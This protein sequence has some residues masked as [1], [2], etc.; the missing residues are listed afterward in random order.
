MQPQALFPSTFR[1]LCVAQLMLPWPHL[2][3]KGC[4]ATAFHAGVFQNV[5]EIKDVSLYLNLVKSYAV[6]NAEMAVLKL[7][8]QKKT[9]AAQD[10]LLAIDKSRNLL[11]AFKGVA[12]QLT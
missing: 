2:P 1:R 10:L 7:A 9:L 8:T 12:E 3:S 11:A 5:E 4:C 6:W